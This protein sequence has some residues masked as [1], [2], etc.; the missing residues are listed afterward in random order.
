[1][2]DLTPWERALLVYGSTRRDFGEDMAAHLRGG[3]VYNGPA[4]F[5]MFRGVRKAAP[6]GAILDPTHQ[7]TA[8][9]C[10]HVWLAA[11]NWRHILASYLPYPLPWIS[12]ERDFVLR[13][14]PLEKLLAKAKAVPF[15]G[16]HGQ[17]WRLQG[18]NRGIEESAP[19]NPRV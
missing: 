11:G 18:I 5:V 1:M 10:W 7:F 17:G 15:A 4:G 9:D 6:D 8:P 16:G 12:W 2:P 14:Y 3:Y 19:G 13:F